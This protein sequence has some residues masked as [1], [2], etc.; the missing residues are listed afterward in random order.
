MEKC[1]RPH[2]HAAGAHALRQRFSRGPL[3]NCQPDRQHPSWHLNLNACFLEDASGQPTATA[4]CIKRQSLFMRPNADPIQAL[5]GPFPLPLQALRTLLAQNQLRLA[6]MARLQARHDPAPTA[7]RFGWRRLAR[8][9]GALLLLGLAAG[10]GLAMT[11]L[12]AAGV[13]EAVM[14]GP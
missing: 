10:G 8:A 3:P 14:Q 12:F 4:H 9:A 1:R 11:A 13:G 7:A 2:L 5:R 6:A